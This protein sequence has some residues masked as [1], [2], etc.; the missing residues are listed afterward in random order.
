MVLPRVP[1]KYE[2]WYVAMIEDCQAILVEKIHESRMI[3]IE[4]YYELGRR[5]IDEQSNFEAVQ[6][7]GESL[8]A[9]VA[10]DIGKSQRTVERAIQLV[11]KYPDLRLLPEGKNISWTKLVNHYLPVHKEPSVTPDD[12][13]RCP[14]CGFKFKK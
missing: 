2:D 4:A 14:S 7:S 5:I 13:I 3:L 9:Q 6:L 10:R 8:T 11:K 1:T 12:L